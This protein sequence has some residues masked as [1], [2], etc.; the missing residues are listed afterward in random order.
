MIIAL[1]LLDDIP[2]MTIAYD[3]TVVTPRPIRWN[4]HRIIFFSSLMGLFA[5]IQS[6]GL[7]WLGLYWTNNDPTATFAAIDKSQL[8]TMLFLQLAAGGHLL[9]LVVR[10]PYSI[11][12]PPFPSWQLFLAIVATQIVAVLMCGFGILVPALPWAIIGLV[13]VYVLVWMLI[14]DAV[15]WVFLDR[16]SVV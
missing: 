3:N 6:F 12:K 15:K 4:M 2:I 9:L 16:K 8:Q 10:T 1:A 13:R 11:F 7:L 14:I 5:L